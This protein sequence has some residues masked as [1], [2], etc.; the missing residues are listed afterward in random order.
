MPDLP[1]IPW[2]NHCKYHPAPKVLFPKFPFSIKKMLAKD[3]RSCSW[4]RQSW[5]SRPR[6]RRKDSHS[7][8]DDTFL[9]T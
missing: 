8:C 7:R 4:K 6:P 3:L 2:A 5:V 9:I 1:E